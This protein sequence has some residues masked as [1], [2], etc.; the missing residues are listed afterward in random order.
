[1]EWLLMLTTGLAL[2]VLLSPLIILLGTVFVLVPLAH[3]LPPPASVARASFDCPYARRRVNVAFMTPP[4]AERP[5]D[6]LSCSLFSDAPPIRCEKGCLGLARTGW[7]PSPMVP[8]Y[9]LVADGVAP[10]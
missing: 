9:A 6:V 10:R 3:L 5:S 4:G 8:R 7:T 1:M 2:L